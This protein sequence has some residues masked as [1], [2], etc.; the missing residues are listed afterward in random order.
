[1]SVYIIN[2][3]ELSKLFSMIV[4]MNNER[5]LFDRAEIIN[6]KEYLK[7]DK[8][9][10]IESI[11]I[12]ELNFFVE[13]LHISNKLAYVMTYKEKTIEFKDL[14]LKLS[15]LFAN[16]KIAL[17]ILQSLKYNLVSNG[18]NSFISQKDMELLERIEYRL[19][20]KLV[21]NNA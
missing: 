20:N 6:F 3:E 13:R 12:N 8:K 18:G 7:F 17:S 4:S 9:A 21:K 16:S 2:T 5:S 19:L 11:M 14:E 1:M 10:T 15:P